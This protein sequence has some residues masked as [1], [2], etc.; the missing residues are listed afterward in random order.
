MERNSPSAGAEGASGTSDHHA[1]N[2]ICS[3]YITRVC[4]L[5]AVLRPSAAAFGRGTADDAATALRH[6]EHAH[7]LSDI[8]KLTLPIWG[9]LFPAGTSS[10]SAGRDSTPCIFFGKQF[11]YPL[12]RG[13]DPLWPE[14]RRKV[15]ES[16]SCRKALYSEASGTEPSP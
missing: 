5:A 15:R 6:S 12:H 9:G 14:G 7:L 11:H 4:S 3:L 10:P 13:E 8:E 16:T 1:T 2:E